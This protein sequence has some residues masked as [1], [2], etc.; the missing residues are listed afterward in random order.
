[1]IHV[2][3]DNNNKTES[4]DDD[5]NRSKCS[6]DENNKAKSSDGDDSKSESS[7]DAHHDS[8]SNQVYSRHI[9]KNDF[10]TD[11]QVGKVDRRVRE[12]QCSLDASRVDSSVESVDVLMAL[13]VYRGNL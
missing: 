2:S 10:R 12:D 7:E 9:Q 3:N 5:D 4:S 6:D 11:A 1:M 13:N 8:T